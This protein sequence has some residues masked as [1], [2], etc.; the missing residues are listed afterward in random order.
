MMDAPLEIDV[1]T[2][3]SKLDAC[4]DFFF[5]DC[6][7]PD[8]HATASIAQAKLIPMS[9]ITE[10]IGELEMYRDQPIVIHCHHGGR[11]LR[12]ARWLRENGFAK[13]QSMAGGIDL[14]SQEIDA[15]VPRY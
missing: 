4:E 3:K 12:V 9:Q 10:R 13:A 6:R 1:R 14:W 5:V 11:S 2:V 7:E 8:E 15:L